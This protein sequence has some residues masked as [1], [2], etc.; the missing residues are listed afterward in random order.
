MWGSR[1]KIYC[2]QGDEVFVAD[3]SP[4]EEKKNKKDGTPARNAKESFEK[5]GSYR[6]DAKDSE[7]V[8]T[9]T[10]P[11]GTI[12]ELSDRLV[13]YRSDGGKNEFDGELVHWRVF[14]R[15]DHY[16]NQL[17]LIYEDRLEVV[18]FVHDYF[19]DQEQKL[20]G[21]SRSAANI[22]SEKSRDGGSK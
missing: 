15:S 4:A 6:L 13:V 20:S 10:A 7:V 21:F 11:F 3:F 2:A 14:P 22:D 18:S 5:R 12:V 19:V 17:H 8:A 16:S 1:E 9:G